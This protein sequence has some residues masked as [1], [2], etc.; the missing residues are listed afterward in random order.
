MDQQTES[1]AAGGTDAIAALSAAPNGVSKKKRKAKRQKR[2][3]FKGCEVAL[4]QGLIN[5]ARF[6]G[7][8]ELQEKLVKKAARALGESSGVAASSWR[9]NHR[10]R[11]VFLSAQG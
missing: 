5:E 7:W 3:T 8:L 4:L 1:G 9:A 11:I 6:E 2:H 10:F